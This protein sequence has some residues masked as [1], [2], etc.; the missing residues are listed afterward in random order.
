MLGEPI[1]LTLKFK[2]H[3]SDND[4]A[5][6]LRM[7]NAV[8]FVREV[9]DLHEE[10]IDMYEGQYTISEYAERLTDNG[11]TFG[12][13]SAEVLLKKHNAQQVGKMMKQKYIS[14]NDCDPSTKPIEIP[15]SNGSIDEVEACAYHEDDDHDFYVMC[16]MNL[17]FTGRV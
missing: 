10:E 6:L 17:A 11:I 1:G 14:I 5:S 15:R 2:D 8:I 7:L 9:E 12:G 3:A 16:M 13:F 4:R